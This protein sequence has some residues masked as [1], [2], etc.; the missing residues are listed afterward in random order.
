MSKCVELVREIEIVSPELLRLSEVKAP[1]RLLSGGEMKVAGVDSKSN[2]TIPAC[3]D[4]A[5]VRMLT[6]TARTIAQKRGGVF[7]VNDF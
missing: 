5:D 6:V 7:V 3:R 4:D 1:G 2:V